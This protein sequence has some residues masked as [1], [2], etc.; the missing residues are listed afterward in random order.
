MG[1][2]LQS[3]AGIFMHLARFAGFVVKSAGFV[4]CFTRKE[5]V[6]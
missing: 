5:E 2:F 1:R 3:H 4:S 6:R